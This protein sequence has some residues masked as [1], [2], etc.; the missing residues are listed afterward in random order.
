[1]AGKFKILAHKMIT[2]LLLAALFSTA[3][4]PLEIAQLSPPGKSLLDR[5]QDRLQALDT[6]LRDKNAENPYD[7]WFLTKQSFPEAP[8]GPKLLAWQAAYQKL[9]ESAAQVSRDLNLDPSLDK[10]IERLIDV[11]LEIRMAL[12]GVEPFKSRL[13]A[14]ESE[15]ERLQVVD[16]IYD[17]LVNYREKIAAAQKQIETAHQRQLN[18]QLDGLDV[19]HL[20]VLMLDEQAWGIFHEGK[21]IH[22]FDIPLAR[23]GQVMISGGHLVFIGENSFSP[24]KSVQIL[25]L[26]DLDYFKNAL[27]R[28]PV[29]IFKLPIATTTPL[30]LTR[31]EGDGILLGSEVLSS[32]A[33]NFFSHQQILFWNVAVNLLDPQLLPSATDMVQNFMRY[34]DRASAMGK[35]DLAGE[36]GITKKQIVDEL[37][38]NVED[39]LRQHLEFFN[40]RQLLQAQEQKFIRDYPALGKQLKDDLELIQGQELKDVVAGPLRRFKQSWLESSLYAD[41]MKKVDS[42]LQAQRKLSARL[43][44]IWH[45]LTIARPYGGQ[46]VLQALGMMAG[47]LKHPWGQKSWMAWKSGAQTLLKHPY[48]RTG[49]G[50]A[51][52][53]VVGEFLFPEAFGQYLQATFNTIQDFAQNTYTKAYDIAYLAK[54]AIHDSSLGANPAVS[55]E[56]YFSDGR[57]MMGVGFMAAIGMAVVFI[58]H[59]IINLYHLAKDLQQSDLLT[60]DEELTN[61]L[62][63]KL[64]WRKKFILAQ[65]KVQQ[66]YL[67]LM[68]QAVLRIDQFEQRENDRLNP[69][70][71][72]KV[73]FLATYGLGPERGTTP[74]YQHKFSAWFSRWGG[75]L[76]STFKN[77]SLAKGGT[78]RISSMRQALGSFICSWATLTRTIKAY[79][80]FWWDGYFTARNFVPF[81]TFNPKKFVISPFQAGALLWFPK[82]YGVAMSGYKKN[83]STIPT[84]LNGGK[85]NMGEFSARLLSKL[86][87]KRVETLPPKVQQQ[88]IAVFNFTGIPY[89]VGTK[90]HIAL[91]EKFEAQ[92]IPAERYLQQA[93][94]NKALDALLEFSNNPQELLKL[95]EEGGVQRITDAS[96]LMTARSRAFFQT[97]YAALMEKA[98]YT[99]LHHLAEKHDLD[100]AEEMDLDLLKDRLAEVTTQ[101]KLNKSSADEIVRQAA[102]EDLANYA[103][104]VA[105]KTYYAYQR[106][107][108]RLSYAVLEGF[109]LDQNSHLQRVAT[110]RRQ[111]D[112]PDAMARAV[113]ASISTILIDQPMYLIL[114]FITLAGI[115][116]GILNPVSQEAWGDN[117]FFYLSRY[118]FYNS[119]LMGV[120]MSFV[121]D[122]GTKLMQDVQH[123]Q[124]FNV[125]PDGKFRK[126][127]F[128]AYYLKFFK[129]DNNTLLQNQWHF[130]RIMWI[131]MKA[132]LINFTLVGL[133]TMGRMDLDV[134]IVSYLM[135]YCTPFSGLAYK[136][137][138]SFE[139]ATGY[140]L[141]DIP[142]R[143]RGNMTV[144]QMLQKVL[145]FKRATYNFFY[146]FYDDIVGL[147]MANFETMSTERF[148]RRT[149]SKIITGGTTFTQFTAQLLEKAAQHTG[150]V[151]GLPTVLRTCE[152]LFT[153]HF[154]DWVE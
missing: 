70:D 131:N 6:A 40:R 4:F 124:D 101:I 84:K 8:L 61:L 7:L 24:E 9:Q 15:R 104:Q 91:L 100:V 49:V 2:A 126:K 39:D 109:D 36:F 99:F 125:A 52:A 44:M 42:N 98:T 19:D 111:M 113:R 58:P 31:P 90:E 143:L 73:A 76:K 60:Y 56:R 96:H 72:L 11:R 38:D 29:P 28:T 152:K 48:V 102:S 50:L 75:K 149:L 153:N 45:R 145:G 35:R 86:V 54:M 108:Q 123:D 148:G 18:E 83:V 88:I 95:I 12:Q 87:G 20:Q 89:L 110:V 137:E 154:D 92:I 37:L 25:G 93:V 144:Q 59:L 103:K 3:A 80:A 139:L 23:P 32:Q 134:Y 97:Y 57:T 127:S 1:M 122:A 65:N 119:F 5:W 41:L 114:T 47:A 79:T 16:K 128:L 120:I 94:L 77:T 26:I 107:S 63:P 22:R 46:T 116:D 68:A 30:Y 135:S 146:Q 53:S 69:E 150:K 136:L 140:Y 129:A 132:A 82:Y 66:E 62:G 142:P 17:D 81:L 147:V 105:T 67:K 141:K 64:T 138:Q 118:V 27:G 51:A 74:A 14:L 21:L 121:G 13:A 106:W 78:A 71:Q 10:N 117:S 85:Q 151:P 133:L 112:K 55:W 43:R 33:M 130:T 34:W 115:T